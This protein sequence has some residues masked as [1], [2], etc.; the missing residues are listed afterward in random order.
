MVIINE[1]DWT[2]SSGNQ[3][4]GDGG[5]HFI[6]ASREGDLE[7]AG[8]YGDGDHLTLWSAGDAAPGQPQAL[9]YVL[10]EDGYNNDGNPFDDGALDA[11]LNAAGNWV[12]ASDRNRKQNIVRLD[13]ALD[14][15]LNIN[16]YSYEF[17][18]TPEELKKGNNPSK[19]LGVIAQEV[20]QVLPDVVENSDAGDYFVSYTEFIPVLIEAQKEAHQESV[21]K[22]QQLQTKITEQNLQIQLLQQQLELLKQRLEVL[23]T[24]AK[25]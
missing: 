8:I 7:S 5:A 12:S 2:H 17:K 14:K 25:N 3:D 19:A 9:I 1:D 13:N 24:S 16:S 4:F 11:Y 6:M 21:T 15:I 20:E 22:N 18:L 10:D 23:E